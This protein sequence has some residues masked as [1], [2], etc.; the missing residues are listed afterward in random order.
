MQKIFDIVKSNSAYYACDSN[1]DGITAGNTKV[2]SLESIKVTKDTTFHNYIC[3]RAVLQTGNVE[4]F[5]ECVDGTDQVNAYSV[6]PPYGGERKLEGGSITDGIA[7]KYCCTE[8]S[9]TKG[10]VD[11]LDAQSCVAASE[12]DGK[13]V[14]NGQTGCEVNG[15][16]PAK[17]GEDK[18]ENPTFPLQGTTVC[19][20]DDAGEYYKITAIAN[21]ATP[22]L[23]QYKACCDKQTDCVDSIGTCRNESVTGEK[24]CSDNIDNDCDGLIDHGIADSDGNQL[25]PPDPDCCGDGDVYQTCC[26]LK[27]GTW[28]NDS[29][30]TYCCGD[31]TPEYVVN[32]TITYPTSSYPLGPNTG[33]YLFG[34]WMTTRWN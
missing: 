32:S 3:Y 33:T 26:Q 23:D 29:T 8:E 2:G 24:S 19:C 6:S 5:A 9:A 34:Y 31:D 25:M 13:I 15:Y 20:G 1:N 16:I 10:W 4:R 21:P 12:S 28:F 14:L 22:G 7:A 18:P 17:S 11:D 30:T 27:G